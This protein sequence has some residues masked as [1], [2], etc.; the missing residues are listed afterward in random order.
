M[1]EKWI[2]SVAV[3]VLAASAA[4]CGDDVGAPAAL[5]AELSTFDTID[6]SF[7]PPGGADA[8]EVEARLDEGAWQQLGEGPGHAERLVLTLTPDAPE[9]A[10]YSFRIRAK[11]G[12]ATSSWSAVAT[13]HRGVRPATILQVFAMFDAPTIQ[14]SWTRGSTQAQAVRLDRRLVRFDGMPGEWSELAGI[15]LDATS[16][17][18]ADI[19]SW[20]DGASLEY[21][22][23]YLKGVTES[24]PATGRSMPARPLAP[25]GLSCTAAGVSSI[26]LDWMPRSQYATK[27]V[28]IRSPRWG[29][30]SDEVAELPKDASAYVDTV[31]APGAYVY[32]ISARMGDWVN[33]VN[34]VADGEPAG[35]FT[36]LPDVP[37]TMSSFAFPGGDP[38]ARGTDGRFATL[39]KVLGMDYTVRTWLDTPGGWEARDATLDVYPTLAPRA[40]LFGPGDRLHELYARIQDVTSLHA[41]LDGTWQSDTIPTPLPQDAVVDAAGA[42]HVIACHEGFADY[43]TNA[44]GAWATQRLPTSVYADRCAIAV[45]PGGDLRV[46]YTSPQPVPPGQGGSSTASDLYLMTGGG[47]Q[48]TEELVPLGGEATQRYGD[49]LRAFALSADRT[50]LLYERPAPEVSDV[51]LGSIERDA[52]GWG[53]P[54]AVGLR[55]F[56]GA[57]ESF[58]AAM[59]P[60]GSRVAIAWNGTTYQG[61]GSPAT[62]AICAAP[63]VWSSWTLHETGLGVG[64]GF[65]PTG[66]LWVLD[67]LGGTAGGILYEEP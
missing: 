20:L 67:G 47:T 28:V 37:L 55:R 4:G 25:V 57:Q 44:S 54:V 41:W 27:Q 65:S 18:D 6:L 60:D 42:L 9:D 15:A 17:A 10:D 30:G 61:S 43:A 64:V 49:V 11:R 51:A 34:Y 45:G 21:R 24:A 53:P 23:V 48:W 7:R 16:Y 13:V 66:K 1:R 63:G 32:R 31:P 50:L 19:G 33:V 29:P 2:R 22:I 46:A 52:T 38:A 59:S 56:N 3:L 35:G 40:I 62:L 58:A 12:G 14:I 8:L 39:G 5:T 26:R 36:A